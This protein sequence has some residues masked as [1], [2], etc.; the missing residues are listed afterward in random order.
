MDHDLFRLVRAH[1]GN[2]SAEHGI[3]LL[4][5]EYISYSRSPAGFRCKGL[6]RT[7][8]PHGILNPGK[9][10]ELLDGPISHGR[11]WRFLSSPCWARGLRSRQGAPARLAQARQA[12]AS[13]SARA[14]RASKLVEA[15]FAAAPLVF[16][17][18]GDGTLR[19]ANTWLSQRLG[20]AP[21]R[22]AMRAHPPP[23]PHS[24]GAPEKD[25]E[26]LRQLA[27]HG[28]SMPYTQRISDAERP[29]RPVQSLLV[30][31]GSGA[32]PLC[33]F[34][35]E[36][37][38]PALA[39]TAVPAALGQAAARGEPEERTAALF[40]VLDSV[41]LLM[42]LF[43]AAGSR[44]RQR[45]VEPAA[46][47]SVPELRERGLSAAPL[48]AGGRPIALQRLLWPALAISASCRCAAKT[49]SST[50]KSGTRC[51]CRQPHPVLWP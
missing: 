36:R 31:I 7:L 49:A 4:K 30:R 2:I 40:A 50:I 18:D 9:V 21:G 26:A 14:G 27:R 22:S 8:D 15:L 45:G 6:K 46:R 32:R 12:L 24:A 39:G 37:G 13:E 44:L 43:S 16:I 17:G 42:V 47:F 29:A 23:R 41:P 28:R 38:E 48:G 25:E 20:Y 5:S 1:A 34:V 3:G 11:R 10:L 33:G 35:M 19:R 51:A